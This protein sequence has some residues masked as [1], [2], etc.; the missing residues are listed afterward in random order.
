MENSQQTDNQ[1]NPESI[2]AEA[3][4]ID[5]LQAELKR[6]NYRSRFLNLL[7]S[8][9][10]ALIVVAACAVLVAVIFL[11]VLRIYG[12][13]MNPTLTEGDIVVSVKGADVQRGD[14]VGVYYGSK[15]LIKR[16]IA[17]EHQWVNIDKNGNVY[18]DGQ[19]IDEPYVQEKAFGECN[20]S[21][22][23]QVPDNTIFVMGDHRATSVD[24]RNTSVGCITTEDVVGKIVFRVWPLKSFGKVQ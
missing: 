12:S 14:I 20:I 24:S 16:C 15:L 6:V 10:S 11:P 18:V 22:P 13:S 4:D 3:L 8:T 1:I 9:I 17:S 19:L 2:N 7:R 5:A 21:L 23:Y